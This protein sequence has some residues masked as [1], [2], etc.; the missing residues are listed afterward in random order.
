MNIDANAVDTPSGYNVE[1]LSRIMCAQLLSCNDER[2]VRAIVREIWRAAKGYDLT[3]LMVNADKPVSAYM[4]DTL[5]A[6][7]KKVKEGNPVQYILGH[8]Y[9]YGM[10]LEVTPD[11]LIPRPETAELV[12]SIVGTYHS[13][14]DLDI[15]DIGTGSGCIA[16]ALSRN[17]P[18]SRV[19]AIDISE[20]ALAIARLNAVNLKAGVRYLH[21]D[22]L[23]ATPLEVPCYDIIVSN[24][25]YILRSEQ[26]D[27][28]EKVYG[29]EPQTALFVDDN[30]PILFYRAICNYAVA[31]LRPGGTL[32][33]ELNPL[34]AQEVKEYIESQPG[35]DEPAVWRDSHGKLRFLKVAKNERT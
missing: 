23:K 2:E 17:L 6:I 3:Q 10:D 32:Y 18:F 5:L 9:F 12:D 31:A 7:V 8:A 15:L 35:W 30:N 33:F 20:K 26:K 24:P 1:Q 34:S 4:A 21:E 29:H 16:I 28:E 14:T 27:M 13:R 22:I 25:P 19:T 11:T